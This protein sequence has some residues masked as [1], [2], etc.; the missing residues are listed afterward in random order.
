ME[1]PPAISPNEPK[2]SRWLIHLAAAA[3]W[4]LIV[5]NVICFTICL[6]GS[7]GLVRTTS[8]S[9]AVSW[10]SLIFVLIFVAIPVGLL[11]LPAALTHRELKWPRFACAL[12]F[13]PVPF[14]VAVSLTMRLLRALF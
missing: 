3:F 7:L 5:M 9:E 13:I 1:V 2:P 14:M 10:A 6:I 11:A 4:L 8:K 12:G